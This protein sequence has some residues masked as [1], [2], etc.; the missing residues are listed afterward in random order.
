MYGGPGSFPLV[1][2]NFNPGV[3]VIAEI[4]GAG[5]AGG[6]ATTFEVARIVDICGCDSIVTY[7]ADALQRHRGGPLQI[8]GVS[9]DQGDLIGK[10]PCGLIPL[11]NAP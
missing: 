1:A 6:W 4:C 11:E 9:D 8:C 10:C 5:L 2:A 7:G 3:V